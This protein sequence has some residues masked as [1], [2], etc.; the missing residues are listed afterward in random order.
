M[1]TFIC[2]LRELCMISMYAVTAANSETGDVL[3]MIKEDHD[4]YSM[5]VILT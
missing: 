4:I 1:V 3:P 5:G 2:L